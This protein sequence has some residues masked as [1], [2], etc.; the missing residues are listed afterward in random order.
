MWLFQPIS[1]E[2]YKVQQKLLLRGEGELCLLGRRN[3]YDMPC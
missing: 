1:D 2:A 3:D